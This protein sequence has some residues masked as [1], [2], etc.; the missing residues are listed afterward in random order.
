MNRIR[1][2]IA[3]DNILIQESI[4]RFLEPRFEVVTTAVDGPAALQAAVDFRPDILTVD[5]SI[6][7]LNGFAVTEKLKSMGFSGKVIFVTAY[8]ELAYMQR[9]FALGASG[10]V[11]K[12]T[13]RSELP[14]AIEETMKGAT[15]QTPLIAAASKA[16]AL[17]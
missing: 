4:R 7:I 1:V 12:G 16:T 2:I 9:A 5:V 6:P 3:E 15:Y 14:L 17:Y 11:L 13:M 10:Y 8:R